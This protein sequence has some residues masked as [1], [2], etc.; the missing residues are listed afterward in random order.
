MSIK[1]NAVVTLIV[2]KSVF[3]YILMGKHRNFL[4]ESGTE[5]SSSK[6][7]H[8]FKPF[9]TIMS[10]ATKE[11]SVVSLNKEKES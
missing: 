9:V 5:Y 6:D 2:I 11:S 4:Y 7:Q 3:F 1:T 10:K 8:I